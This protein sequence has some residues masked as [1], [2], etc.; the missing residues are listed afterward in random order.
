MAAPAPLHAVTI[1]R[2]ARRLVWLLVG[3]LTATTVVTSTGWF[4][5]A[6]EGRGLP[7]ECYTLES[8]SAIRF[9]VLHGSDSRRSTFAVAESDTQVMIG[10]WQEVEDGFHTAEGYAGRLGYTLTGPLGDRQ[11]VDPA[12]DPVPSC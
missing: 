4:L 3:L 7:P 2:S 11:V 12:G 8:P 1:D 10:Y 9:D 5:S 6:R